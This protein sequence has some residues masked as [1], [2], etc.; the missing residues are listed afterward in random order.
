MGKAT[1]LAMIAAALVVLA[2]P[3]QAGIDTHIFFDSDSVVF[4]PCADGGVG[5]FVHLTGKLHILGTTTINGNN[6]SGT[7]HMQPQG[8]SGVGLTTGDKYHATGIT[9]GSFKG[10]VVNGQYQESFENNF[11]IIGQG[12]GNNLLVHQT[13]HITF[14]ANGEMTASVENIK[15]E[16]K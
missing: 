8:I 11:R 10:S 9:K 15:M 6:F 7:V 14:K 12:P 16:C 13:I 4:V 1:K 3:V 2:A 5:E